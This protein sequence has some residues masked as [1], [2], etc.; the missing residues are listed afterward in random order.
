MHAHLHELLS[1]RDGEPVAQPAAAHVEGCPLCMRR[2]ADLHA[3]RSR[4]RTLPD[5]VASGR[6]GYAEVERR[7]A[8]R[9]A[10]PRRRIRNAVL[11]AA[12]SVA[13]LAVLTNLRLQDDGWGE[14]EPLA[15]PRPPLIAEA[16]LVAEAPGTIAELQ[17]QSLELET[18]LASLPERPAVE[19][20]ATALPI[21]TLEAQV[22]WVDHRLLESGAVATGADTEQLWRDRIEIMNSLVQLRYVEAQRLAL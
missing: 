18:L 10:A 3:T 13:S 7:I 14:P 11:A 21:E 9:A 19:R 22:Q 16:P 2:L 15:K 5:V 6:D 12:A 8:E 4:L 17:R 20:A 1:L